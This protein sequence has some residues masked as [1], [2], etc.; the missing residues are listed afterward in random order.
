MSAEKKENSNNNNTNAEIIDLS[1]LENKTEIK[2]SEYI[3]AILEICINS[4][5]Y[6]LP[7]SNSTRVFWEEVMNNNN[8]FAILKL[9]KAETLRKYWRIM[10]DLNNS[11]KIIS[12][13]TQHSHR[14]DNPCYK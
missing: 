5:K 11:D 1:S 3:L 6:N 10:R 9:F 4:H 2:N 12:I 7:H 13:V 14:I 8:L